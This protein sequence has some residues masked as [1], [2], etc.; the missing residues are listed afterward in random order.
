MP[1][2]LKRSLDRYNFLDLF[3]ILANQENPA[4]NKKLF[5]VGDE[6]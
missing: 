3:S 1:I 4:L 2:I 6:G 5:P